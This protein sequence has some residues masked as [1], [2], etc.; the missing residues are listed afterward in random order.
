M[1]FLVTRPETD[2]NEMR[3]KLE[4]LGHRVSLAPLLIIEDTGG[5]IGLAGVQALIATSRNALRALA[6]N[7]ACAE[8]ITLPIF[9]VG[10]ATGADARDLGFS[11]VIEG[12]AAGHDLVAVIAAD[13][14]PA[15]GALLHLTGDKLAF[16]LAGLL[17]ERGFDVR[18]T[19]VYRSLPAERFAAEVHDLIASGR[20]D[21]VIL[22]SPLT[23]ATFASLTSAAGLSERA[24]RITY[25]CLSEA[26]AGGLK[27]LAPLRVLVATRANSEEMLALAAGLAAN[28]W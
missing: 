1:H 22:M 8:A 10:P 3:R 2:A 18:N 12:P 13:T 26:V 23:A 20:L 19:C 5:E 17:R 9:A 15:A 16:D 25:L 7:P 28:S 27:P 21:S 4:A 6:R 11:T 14:D 24:S